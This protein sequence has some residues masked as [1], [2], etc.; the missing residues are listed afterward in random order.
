MEIYYWFV[1]PGWRQT[2]KIIAALLVIAGICTLL[3]KPI[4]PT[5]LRRIRLN[6]M[7]SGNFFTT[8]HNRMYPTL[9]QVTE[10]PTITL[11]QPRKLNKSSELMIMTYPSSSIRSKLREVGT[12]DDY[13][14][15]HNFTILCQYVP[16]FVNYEIRLKFNECSPFNYYLTFM[17][18]YSFGIVKYSSNCSFGDI[19]MRY[20]LPTFTYQCYLWAKVLS[21]AKLSEFKKVSGISDKECMINSWP[22]TEKT[23]LG[24]KYIFSHY[25]LSVPYN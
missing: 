19:I 24:V 1:F 12:Y 13:A 11:L 9:S 22:W 10:V 2:F 23:F 3:F 18:I 21:A 20:Y 5:Q 25:H 4:P 17:V 6:A 7:I 14:D 16:N 8:Y 15:C